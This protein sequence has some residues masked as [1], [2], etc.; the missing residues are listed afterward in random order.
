MNDKNIMSLRNVWNSFLKETSPTHLPN[1]NISEILSGITN[2]GSFYSFILDIH[3]LS[4]SN[5]VGDFEKIHGI[6]PENITLDAI[7]SLIHPD[8]LEFIAKADAKLLSMFYNELGPEEMLNYKMSYNYRMRNANGNYV[9]VNHQTVVL[10]L[11]ERKNFSKGLNIHTRIDHLTKENNYKASLIGMNG[12][13]SI[14]DVSLEKLE[15]K[16]PDMILFTSRER[17][18][19]KGFSNG[20]SYKEIAEQ[21]FIS[22][23]TV[24]SHRKNILKKAEVNSI[25]EVIVKCVKWGIIN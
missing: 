22:K 17:E 16:S 18:V 11:D 6:F 20:F 1:K 5:I 23:E 19:I 7:F 14:F 9:L 15:N 8:D 4:I 2:V 12:R 13:D 21:L 3:E 10:T 25:E 24:K